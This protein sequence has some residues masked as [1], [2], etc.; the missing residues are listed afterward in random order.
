M[1]KLDDRIYGSTFAAQPYGYGLAD[2]FIYKR[3]YVPTSNGYALLVWANTGGETVEQMKQS[4]DVTTNPVNVMLTDVSVN[5]LSTVGVT[6]GDKGFEIG[7][8]C[9]AGSNVFV[10]MTDLT[11]QG[12]TSDQLTLTEDSTAKGVKL[13]ILRNGGVP[14]GYGPDS[15]AVGN[16]NQWYVGPSG[17]TSRIPLIAQYIA[18][19]PVSA[20]SVKGVATFTLSYQ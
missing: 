20:G 4:C 10:T 17:S 3:T 8:S 16:T 1:I 19:G 5:S 2:F 18:T 12:N 6:A 13:R 9:K 11:N 14:V 7:L 15:A